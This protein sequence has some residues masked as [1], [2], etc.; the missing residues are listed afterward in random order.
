[1][2]IRWIDAGRVS[3]YRSQSIYHGLGYAQTPETPDTVVMV[4]PENP[5]ICIG[6]FQEAAKEVNL[7]FCRENK[8]PVI[9]RET[10]GGTVYIDS[11]QLFVQWVCQ[12]G[13][14]PLKVEHRFQL[15]N[16]A[17]IETYKFFGIQA[18]HYPVNDVHV[19]GKKIVG[20][21]AATIGNA[22]V[23]TGNFLFD[24]D[25]DIMTQALNLPNA[26]FRNV[27][28]NSLD[29]YMTWMKRELSQPPSYQEVIRVY[30]TKCEIALGAKLIEG[31]FT[32]EELSAIEQAEE[33]LR[34]EDWLHS[35]KSS[36]SKNK[37]V[38]IHAGVWVGWME[39][40]VADFSVQVFSQMRNN[41]LD[42]VR[43]YLPSFLN[44]V[45]DL[46][47]LEEKLISA[48]LEEN[49]IGKRISEFFSHVSGT[50]TLISME[51]WTKAVM[52]IKKEVQKVSG[53]A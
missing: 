19:D 43:F 37:L 44:P 39:V 9:R 26:D 8:L 29:N 52:Q 17:L 24:F 38:K 4:V 53:H 34:S 45:W 50:D 23:V 3:N 25:I 15:F 16:K 28:R 49:E 46:K 30:K 5:Y 27:I 1:M 48:P 47:V 32:Q 35:V 12:P 40:E 51:D 11:G 36:P 42:M 21:G 2:S 20:T 6:Y 41:T 31:N 10:G 14:L 22:E 33:K 18:Y 7:N 13:F